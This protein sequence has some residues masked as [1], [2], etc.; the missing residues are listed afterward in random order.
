VRACLS[1]PVFVVFVFLLAGV[2]DAI[3]AV[4]LLRPGLAIARPAVEVL[5]LVL[6]AAYVGDC[7]EE[8]GHGVL[9]REAREAIGR[10]WG[11]EPGSWGQ[12]RACWVAASAAVD[13][14]RRSGALEVKERERQADGGSQRLARLWP[15]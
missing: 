7:V 3:R 15:H 8:L 13:R 11:R 12:R 14:Q 6:V 5:V 1:Q 2:V 9:T 10:G 4:G